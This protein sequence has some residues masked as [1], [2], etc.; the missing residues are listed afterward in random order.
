MGWYK[1]KRLE[2]LEAELNGLESRLKTLQGNV[3]DNDTKA[4][5][6]NIKLIEMQMGEV[7]KRIQSI[8]T[9]E[10]E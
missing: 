9:E 1:E 8:K 6:R 7:I 2:C 5:R 3:L 10:N 4:N